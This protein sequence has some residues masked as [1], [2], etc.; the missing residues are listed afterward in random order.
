MCKLNNKLTLYNMRTA[1]HHDSQILASYK[2]SHDDLLARAK[3][4]P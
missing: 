2:Q 1:L 3:L 4:N